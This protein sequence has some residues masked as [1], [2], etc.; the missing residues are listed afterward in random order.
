GGRTGRLEISCARLAHRIFEGECTN[1]TQAASLLKDI[2]PNDAQ[3]REDFRTKEE[4]NS[5]KARYL[6]AALEHQ[7][8]L[9]E[10]GGVAAAELEPGGTLTLGDVFPKSPGGG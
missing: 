3:F 5:R 8:R 7:A 10:R 1:T 4:K 6:L 2:L 9:A